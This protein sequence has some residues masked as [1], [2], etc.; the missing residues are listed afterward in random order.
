MTD[1]PFWL[2]Y[3]DCRNT[4]LQ[5]LDELLLAPYRLLTSLLQSQRVEFPAAR[6]VEFNPLQS[7]SFPHAF[8]GNPGEILTLRS[9]QGHGEYSRTM[10][11]P[12]IKTF[13]GDSFEKI[14]MNE[15]LIPPQLAAG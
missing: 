11:G 13:G 1:S 7:P 9:T 10:T 14:I 8:S 2:D 6:C 15:F 5:R 3:Q 12:P 4:L